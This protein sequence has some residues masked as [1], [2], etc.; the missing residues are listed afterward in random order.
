MSPY[1]LL[2]ALAVYLARP[3]FRLLREFAWYIFNYVMAERFGPD[4]L[5]KTSKLRAIPNQDHPP[6]EPPKALEEPEQDK[7]A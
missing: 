3:A 4:V 7:A 2:L 6:P 1:W 5:D